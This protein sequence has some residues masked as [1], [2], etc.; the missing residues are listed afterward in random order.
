MKFCIRNAAAFVFI[1]ICS[2]G[3]SYASDARAALFYIDRSVEA[4]K[5][6]IDSAEPIPNATENADIR[7]RLTKTMHFL[8]KQRNGTR[9][10]RVIFD[11][12]KGSSVYSIKASSAMISANLTTITLHIDQSI[13]LIERFLNTNE[14]DTANTIGTFTRQL[15]ELTESTTDAW[16]LYAMTSGAVSYALVDMGPFTGDIKNIDLNKKLERLVITRS[17]VN[18]LKETLN[19]KFGDIIRPEQ[20]GQRH[21]LQYYQLPVLGLHSF[22]HDKWKASDEK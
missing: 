16:Q 2:L 20:G 8:I 3:P 10:A 14:Y 18:A 9:K 22:L 1:F 17:A 4:Y 13:A 5:I 19:S 15:Q 6:V 11:S 7:S 21:K 12:F